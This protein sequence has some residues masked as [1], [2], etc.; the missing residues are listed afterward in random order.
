MNV[1][2]WLALACKGGGR[3]V[4]DTETSPPARSGMR[5]R[6]RGGVNS[7]ETTSGS[8]WRAREVELV[9]MALKSHE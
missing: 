3:G 9:R 4:N 6:W 1:H 2:L 8:L 7:A 5:G